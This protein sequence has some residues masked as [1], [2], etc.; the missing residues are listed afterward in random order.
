MAGSEPVNCLL[1]IS[2]FLGTFSNYNID[3]Q[4][5]NHNKV[6]QIQGT[7]WYVPKDDIGWENFPA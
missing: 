2:Q 4:N 1:Q 7:I 6:S 5:L 3:S